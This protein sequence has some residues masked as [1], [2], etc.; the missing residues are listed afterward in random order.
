MID[1]SALNDMQ[2]EAVLH[3]DGPCLVLATAGSGKTRV[4]TMRA[5]RLIAEGTRP[6]RI[7]LATFTKKAAEEMR[8]RLQGMVGEESAQPVWI[9]TFHSHCLRILRLT[10]YELGWSSFEVLPPHKALRLARDIL[11][12]AD[13]KHPYG[14]DWQ[15]D[16][17]WALGHIS[18]AKA[19]LVD[20]DQAERWFRERIGL[21]EHVDN[22]VD[23]WRRYEGAKAEATPQLFDFDDLLVKVW[24]LFGSLPG[25]LARWQ[26]AFDYILEDEVQD[27][28]VA[29]HEIVTA[30]A[31]GHR[32]YFAVGDV[33]QSVYGFRGSN[34][35]HT[36]MSFQRVY[37]NGRIIKL[38]IN[39][40]SQ[41]EIV[42]AGCRLIRHNNVSAAYTLDPESHRGAGDPPEVFVSFDEDAEA[43]RIAR[44]ACEHIL[45]GRHYKDIA[46]LY[47]VNAQSRAL[48][49]A[50]VAHQVPYIMHGSCGFYDRREVKDILAYIQLAHDPD[51]DAGNEAIHRVA[52]IATNWFYMGHVKKTS[53]YLGKVFLDQL[54]A[55]ARRSGCSM[56]KALD[57]GDWKRWQVEAIEDLKDF[58]EA[59]RLGAP[60]P[61]VMVAK[62]R[63][64][65]YDAY[66]AR[67]EGAEDEDNDGTRFDNLDELASAAAKFENPA[68]FL[69]FITKQRSQAKS[70][71]RDQDAVQLLTLH[72]AKGLEWPVVYL[73]GVSM[74]LLPHKRSV[75]YFDPE[76][77]RH[78]IPESL[79]EERRL[80]YVGVTRAMDDLRISALLEYQDA[81]LRWS[82]FLDEMGYPAPAEFTQTD[83]QQMAMFQEG[84]NDEWR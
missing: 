4:L 81:S 41:S 37:P 56:W 47:R 48:E 50:M 60:D 22:L 80:A 45:D 21:A 28:M 36:V 58:V 10:H 25:V 73:A 42:A 38:P 54:E 6:E 34:P 64:A 62:A 65:G 61:G 23:F 49:D 17:K 53:H 75:Q 51:C 11:A 9:G 7:L 12:P 84:A 74:G 40:R 31:A 70:L 16:S 33:N 83:G 63:E 1:L 8:T 29:Q 71:G 66:L 67:E 3:G 26:E 32:N 15:T 52:N 46:V 20:L 5:A 35:D 39:Y 19:D 55:L 69:A 27:T 2:K 76:T 18:R 72:R 82:P 59:V 77:K 13:D 43:D 30:L 68:A 14:M 24:K 57:R 79:E 78:I 44:E